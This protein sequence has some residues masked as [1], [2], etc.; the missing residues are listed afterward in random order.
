VLN[1]P[2]RLTILRILMAPVIVICVVYRRPAWALGLLC[3]AALTDALD[4][5]IARTRGQRTEL[6]R[7]LDP[8]ADKLL[9]TSAFVALAVLGEIRRWLAIIVVSRDLILVGGSLLTYLLLGKLRV[10]PSP[11][12]KATT[13]LQLALVIAAVLDDLLPGAAPGLR[14]LTWATAAAT[15]ASG[16]DYVVRGSR[17]LAAEA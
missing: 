15:V 13:G 12:G 3:A 16:L 4:G 10:A 14:I 7:I 5:F 2:N 8:L 17:A 6:G 1:L 9:L 11:L